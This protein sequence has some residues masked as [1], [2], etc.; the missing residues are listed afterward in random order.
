L[1]FRLLCLWVC[2]VGVVFR[3]LGFSAVGSSDIYEN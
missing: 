3:S 1:F 2:S